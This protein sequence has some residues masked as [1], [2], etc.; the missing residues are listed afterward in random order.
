MVGK[1]ASGAVIRAQNSGPLISTPARN[2]C[3]AEIDDQRDD[4]DTGCRGFGG[5]EIGRR[6]GEDRDASHL[7]L[8]LPTTVGP[9]VAGHHTSRVQPF[10][11]ASGAWIVR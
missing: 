6:V 7:G 4:V 1:G 10:R 5:V 8:L 3:V 9:V 2:D 11:Y